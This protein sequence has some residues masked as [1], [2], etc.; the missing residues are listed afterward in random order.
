M[1]SDP[2]WVAKQ[3]NDRMAYALHALL[4]DHYEMGRILRFREIRRGAQAECFEL[5]TAEQ[6]EFLLFLY[7]PD[8]SRRTLCD[9]APVMDRLAGAGFPI[10]RPVASRDQDAARR[11]VYAIEGPQGSHFFVTTLAPGQMVV[12]ADWSNHN[13]S[14][15]G[16]RLGWLHRTMREAFSADATGAEQNIPSAGKPVQALVLR[17]AAALEGASPRGQQIRQMLSSAAV[18]RLLT[19]LEKLEKLPN[20]AIGYVHGAIS[21]DAVLLDHDR[22]I[23]SLVDWGNFSIG[24]P[25]QDV[26][27]AFV[28]WCVHKDGEVRA[29]A[30]Q[31]L[32]QA[33]LSLE[34]FRGDQWHSVVIAWCAH[35]LT[36]A[37]LGR[38]H[39][40][41]GFGSILEN[42]HSLSATLTIC[43]SKL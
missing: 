38:T 18:D 41:R 21:P 16:L 4:N 42:P 26:I 14:N 12:A 9:A 24:L 7:P 17:L 32:L 34:K 3:M 1:W 19:D 25:A 40:P 2:A 35:R 11:N 27:D 8:F 15:L 22:H 31:A 28:H 5:L 13:L 39:L 33:Y 10:S 30:A 29:D 6:N 43:Q 23:A 36:A 20:S 37:L